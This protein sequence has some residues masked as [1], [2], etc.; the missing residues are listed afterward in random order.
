MTYS[1]DWDYPAANNCQIVIQMLNAKSW[2]VYGSMW[3][4]L[5]T[6]EPLP[7]QT[8]ERSTYR[9]MWNVKMMFAAVYRT[10]LFERSWLKKKFSGPLISFL[11]SFLKFSKKMCTQIEYNMNEFYLWSGWLADKDAVVWCSLGGFSPVYWSSGPA[12]PA[13]SH[14]R[15]WEECPCLLAGCG[16]SWHTAAEWNSPGSSLVENQWSWS[17]GRVGAALVGVPLGPGTK[18]CGRTE[19][20]PFT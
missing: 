9:L 18:Y 17:P 19:D 20:Y 5:N 15:C 4:H 11:N 6:A 13:Q 3:H 10:S 2:F 7:L 16:P 1:F 12:P 8:N 14:W